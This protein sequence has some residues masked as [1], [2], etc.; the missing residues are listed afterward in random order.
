MQ[1]VGWAECNEFQVLAGRGHVLRRVDHDIA[2]FPAMLRV[3]NISAERIHQ[4][5]P[6]VPESEALFALNIRAIKVLLGPGEEFR[7]LVIFGP[8]SGWSQFP[9][10]TNFK[11]ALAGRV[12]QQIFAIAQVSR[13][14]G[15]GKTIGVAGIRTEVRATI[16]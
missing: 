16:L 9:V 3:K 1:R 5:Q 6:F 14:A 11:V 13:Q 8:R 10:I 2:V 15:E 7:D 12:V 4:V